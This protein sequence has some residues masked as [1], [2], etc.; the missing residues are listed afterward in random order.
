MRWN[1]FIMSCGVAVVALGF[2]LAFL[3][4]AH[5]AYEQADRETITTER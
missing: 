1:I 3:E 5:H 4:G 2:A